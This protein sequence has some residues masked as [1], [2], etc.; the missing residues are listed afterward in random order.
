MV[1]YYTLL[2]ILPVYSAAAACLG[3]DVN[4]AALDLV[5]QFESFQS[6]ICESY[7]SD[8]RPK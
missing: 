4:H 7:M 3:P 1:P 5:Q 6:I 2:A 8:Q